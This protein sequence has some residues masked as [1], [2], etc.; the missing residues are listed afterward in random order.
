MHDR[1]PRVARELGDAADVAGGD[2]IGT[3]QRDVGQLA[4]AQ[5][6]RQLRL[7]EVIGPGRAA[8]QVAFR[9]LD[10][11]KP[12]GGE[13]GAG[14][15]LDPLAVLQRAGGM[16]GDPQGRHGA[17][18][19]SKAEFGDGFADVAGDRGD[20]RRLFGIGRIVAQEEPVILDHRPATRGVDDD[21]VEPAQRPRALPGIDI[22][23]G[24]GQ[25]RCLVAEV[26]LK[27]AAAAAARRD[28][29]LNAVPGQQPDRRLVDL[30]RQHLLR[31]AG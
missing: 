15:A 29:N 20:P 4:L 1:Q 10:H 19:G 8:A 13:Q 16:I 11:Q 3:G 12:G 17:I 26:V 27:R 14:F 18:W 5:R 31:A 23:A 28:D 30:G 7:Q 24:Q 6:R 22:R 9:H 25:R 2:E 21:G